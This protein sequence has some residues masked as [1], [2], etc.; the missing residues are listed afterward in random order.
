VKRYLRALESQPSVSRSTRERDNC[1]Q[2]E[3][4]REEV[5]EMEL[6]DAIRG[7]QRGEVACESG[8]V[9]GDV[10]DVWGGDAFE[11]RADFEARAGAWWVEDDE[12]GTLALDDGL[13]QKGQRGFGD[14]SVLRAE[15]FECGG[16]VGGG[17][18]AGLDGGDLCEAAGE[19]AGEEADAGEEVPC[20]VAGARRCV[21]PRDEI[22]ER[23]DEEAVDLEEAAAGDPVRLVAYF[24]VEA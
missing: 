19:D 15:L 7:L 13:L 14:G 4:L 6:V 23:G 21:V 8:G 20:D 24:V 1:F 9:A 10:D 11:Q 17:Y 18:V 22:D 16:E 2:M 3:G 12:V 5:D